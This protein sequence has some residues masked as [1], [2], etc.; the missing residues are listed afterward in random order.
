MAAM[1]PT[2][3]TALAAGLLAPAGLLG[4][5]DR[6][7]GDAVIRGRAGPSDIVI[8]T[9]ART[10]GAIH[11]LTWN[12]KEFIDSNDHGRQLQSASAFD[13]GDAANFWAEA[14][15]PTEAG[16]R[17][18]GVG[19]TSTSRLLG[20]EARGNRLNTVTRMAFWVPPGEKSGAHPAKNTTRLSNHLLTK[21]V[22][23]GYK[24]LPH[25]IDYRVTFAV[26]PTD[27]KHTLA[28][29]E[30]VTGY[31][32]AEFSTFETFDPGSG[33]L[34]AISDG[35]GGQDKPLVFSTPDGLWAM[36]VWT[37]EPAN[38]YGR[39]R[40]VPDKVVKWNCVFRVE[41]RAGVKPGNFS[42]RVFVAV[43]SRQNVRDTLVGLVQD[44]G[45]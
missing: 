5:R 41:D 1:T 8:T 39:W 24:G 20:L 12:G 37:P 6:P 28:Q 30:A 9:T 13:C 19:P 18:D 32:P 4:A 42:Y 11:S 38:H 44:G 35:P 2:R 34:A 27:P 29:F 7:P 16:G 26:P 15:N 43:G 22:A 17:A 45:R 31:M 3:R 14:Y 40:F 36:G 25:A 23:I 21:Q 10:A 33:R